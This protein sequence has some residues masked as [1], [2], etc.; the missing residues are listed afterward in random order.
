[1]KLIS[2]IDFEPIECKKNYEEIVPYLSLRYFRSPAMNVLCPN[3]CS[4]I[5]ITDAPL[6]Y[7]MLPNRSAISSGELTSWLSGSE[8][9]SESAP[10]TLCCCSTTNC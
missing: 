10:K 6:L 7:E 9:S 1:M 3:V 2:N 8:S 4:T 5:R